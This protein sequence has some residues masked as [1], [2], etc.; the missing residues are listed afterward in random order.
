MTIF[1]TTSVGSS[2]KGSIVKVIGRLQVDDFAELLRTVQQVDDP[3]E[4][5]LTELQ[6]ID[7][8]TVPL[9]RDLIGRGVEVRS[10]SPYITLLLGS[11]RQA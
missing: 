2:G 10:A 11:G 6:S 4:M 3:V 8:P 5:D 7:R 9:L 1:I